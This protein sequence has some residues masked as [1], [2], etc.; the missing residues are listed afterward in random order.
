MWFAMQGQYFEKKKWDG[1]PLPVFEQVRDKLPEPIFEDEDALKAYWKSW[2]MAIGSM[3]SP[4]EGSGFVSNFLYMEFSN[5]IFAHD[6]AIMVLFAKYGFRAFPSAESLDNFY[7]RQHENGEICREIRLTGDDYWPNKDGLPLRVNQTQDGKDHYYWT[8]PF[9]DGVAPK[10]LIDGLNDPSAMMWAE[11]EYYQ[12]TGDRARLARI[13]PPQEKWFEAFERFLKDS[14][15]LYI[16]DWAS[17][18]N[19]PRNAHNVAHGVDVAS[20]QAYLARLLSQGFRELG[21]EQKAARYQQLHNEISQRIQRLMWNESAGFYFDLDREGKHIP[22]KTALGFNALLTA[23]PGGKEVARLAEHL[24]N[25]ASFNRPVRVPS[26]AADEADYYPGGAYNLGGVWPFMNAAVLAGLEHKGKHQLA[27]EIAMNYLQAHVEVFRNTGTVWE[28]LAPE[29]AAPG[30]SNNPHN[31]GI[32]AR[33]DFAGWGAYSPIANLLEYAI[34]LRA[35]APAGE[36]TWNLRQ[37]GECGCR[38]YAFGDVVVDIVCE[39]RKDAEEEPVIRAST[40]RPFKLK[41]NWGTGKSK[42]VEIS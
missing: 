3:R 28:F 30:E 6:T 11:W 39:A 24:N 7:A 36:L 15:G 5:S 41:L 35:N 18:D 19:S 34:G 25:P 8:P 27:Y 17:A 21:D 1:A 32:S 33:K 10:V 31:P 20:Q 14:N 4:Q 38:R 2:E 37:T 12:L 22:I 16:T 13:L 29:K 40:N 26:L 9:S 23:G 42:T